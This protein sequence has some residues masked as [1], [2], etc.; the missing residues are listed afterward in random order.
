MEIKEIL[1]NTSNFVTK[2][3]IELF[4]ALILILSIFLLISLLSYSGNDQPLIFEDNPVVENILFSES[5]ILLF[6]F[7]FNLC[8]QFFCKF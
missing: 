5:S 6:L 3:L 7:I 1:E 2:R 4:G 8:I